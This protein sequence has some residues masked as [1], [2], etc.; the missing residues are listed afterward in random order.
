M[1]LFPRKKKKEKAKQVKT[2]QIPEIQSLCS[3]DGKIRFTH[4]MYAEKHQRNFY[5][6]KAWYIQSLKD[7]NPGGWQ[8]EVEAFDHE[9]LQRKDDQAKMLHYMNETILGRY[10][11]KT[12]QGKTRNEWDKKETK[13]F[14]DFIQF[15]IDNSKLYTDKGMPTP[16][17]GGVSVHDLPDWYKEWEEKNK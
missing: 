5:E 7:E 11:D 3:L 9:V 1:R 4:F 17:L 14:A 13:E 2:E 8:Q 12:R 16:A 10:I 15:I 6:M